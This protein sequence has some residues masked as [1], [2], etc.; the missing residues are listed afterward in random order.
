MN[1]YKSII[2]RYLTK[3]CPFPDA[4]EVA[5][6]VNPFE[7]DYLSVNPDDLLRPSEGNIDQFDRLLSALSDGKYRL[8]VLVRKYFSCGARVVLF[9][10]DP[11][12]NN[13]LDGLIFLKLSDFPQITLR[14]ILRGLPEELQDKVWM[15]FYGTPRN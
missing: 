4:A 14:S 12:F 13:C 5:T 6:P 7:P 15:N 9:N 1:Y 3:N 8:P 11:D 2:V 10:V